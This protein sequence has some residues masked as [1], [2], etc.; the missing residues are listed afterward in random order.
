MSR[1]LQ[2][3][4]IPEPGQLVDVRRRRYVVLDITQ[5]T[6]PPDLLSSH[7]FQAQHQV[8][9][10]SVEDDALGE[11][12]QVIW[13]IEP[14]AA[15]IEKTPLPQPIGF[16][17]PQRL[18]TFLNAVRWG[19][20]S[21]AEV[22]AIQAPFRSGIGKRRAVWQT[23]QEI[24]ALQDWAAPAIQYCR[25]L[26]FE[27]KRRLY[28]PCASLYPS[29]GAGFTLGTIIF[30]Y[31]ERDEKAKAAQIWNILTSHITHSGSNPAESEQLVQ[32]MDAKDIKGKPN[33]L[34]HGEP[35]TR[36]VASALREIVIGDRNKLDISYWLIEHIDVI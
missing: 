24:Q 15:T 14:G 29:G 21:S 7:S 19:A 23:C 20:S 3:P 6:L 35:I 22:K 28:H 31:Q 9:L 32:R 25:A 4:Q 1:L 12:L 27:L 2:I 33:T 36:E 26:E 5:S 11:E 8:T 10:S 30:A 17:T 16:D 34:A 18:D 13:E